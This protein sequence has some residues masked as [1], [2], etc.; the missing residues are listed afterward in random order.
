[1]C[2]VVI[3]N[4][5]QLKESCPDL[6]SSQQENLHTTDDEKVAAMCNLLEDLKGGLRSTSRYTVQVMPDGVEVIEVETGNLRRKMLITEVL[7][8]ESNAQSNS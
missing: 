2:D 1:M 8:D 7:P 4:V 5:A 6:G 3:T